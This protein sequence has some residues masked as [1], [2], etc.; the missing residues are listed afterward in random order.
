MVEVSTAR[1]RELDADRVAHGV[2]RSGIYSHRHGQ[3]TTDRRRSAAPTH[4][5]T[6][7]RHTVQRHRAPLPQRVLESS[8]ARNLRGRGVGGAAV[9]LDGQVRLGHGLAELRASP[10]IRKRDRAC[11]RFPRHASRGSALGQRRL[12]P[13][14]SVP[15]RT[16]PQRLALL[17][18]LGRA[19]IHPRH[20]ARGGRVRQVPRPLREGEIIA[21]RFTMLIRSLAAAL[22]TGLLVSGLLPGPVLA[23]PPPRV[24][25]PKGGPP[26]VTVRL[27]SDAA[28]IEPGSTF[29]VGLR[30]RIAPGWHTYWINPGDSGEPPSIEW[31]LPEGFGAG[32]IVWPRPER[33]KVGPFMSF[34][35][36][37][38]VV[39][40]VQVTAPA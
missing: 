31:K 3:S 34:G 19:S 6:I 35:Y 20:Q 9:L 26:R 16:A 37:R 11:R 39:L 5:G 32:P 10:R 28:S 24:E 27:I 23:V 40:L 15:R 33:L 36:E 21:A 22:F 38:E 2:P 17:H 7:Q 18:Q 30:E 8:R 25:A 1:S 13:R 4:A 29:W 12:A 14:A